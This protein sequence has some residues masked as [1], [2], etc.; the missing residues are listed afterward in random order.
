LL[1]PFVGGCNL[2]KIVDVCALDIKLDAIPWLPTSTPPFSS[3]SP[4]LWD[5]FL[6]PQI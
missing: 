3:A 5:T 4:E 2:K 6:K 1:L